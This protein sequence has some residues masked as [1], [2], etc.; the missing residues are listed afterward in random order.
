MSHLTLKMMMQKSYRKGEIMNPTKIKKAV[1]I[2][3]AELEV[4]DKETVKN[5]KDDK[6]GK[7]Y[8]NLEVMKKAVDK[9]SKTATADIKKRKVVIV[10]EAEKKIIL[11]KEKNLKIKKLTK[12]EIAELAPVKKIVKKRRR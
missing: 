6:I 8:M 12:K 9:L 3:L 7:I 1:D 10:N 4:L 2:I 11:D 5:M